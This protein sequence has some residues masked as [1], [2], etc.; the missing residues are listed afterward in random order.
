[1][2]KLNFLDRVVAGVVMACAITAAAAA[3]D[4]FFAKCGASI[5]PWRMKLNARRFD[6]RARLRGARCGG[7]ER[8]ISS[9]PIECRRETTSERG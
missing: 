7:W 5:T 6:A 4:S 9:I 8:G 1:M 2:V 3:Q